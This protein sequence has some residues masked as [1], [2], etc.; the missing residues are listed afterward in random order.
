MP[1]RID[2]LTDDLTILNVLP[3][4]PAGSAP[5]ELES[6][7]AYQLSAFPFA[8]S[9]IVG[10][11]FNSL[12]IPPPGCPA[13]LDGDGDADADDFFT[14]LDLFANADA[15]ADIDGDGDVDADDFFAYLDVFAAGC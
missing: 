8:S 13:D 10:T 7:K 14:Y 6:N 1:F 2:N 15:R 9:K 11:T 5:V 12:V 3:G 4:T